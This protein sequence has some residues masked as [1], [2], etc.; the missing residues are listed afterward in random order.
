MSTDLDNSFVA[1]DVEHY[2]VKCQSLDL[3]DTIKLQRSACM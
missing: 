2:Q 1:A 3:S